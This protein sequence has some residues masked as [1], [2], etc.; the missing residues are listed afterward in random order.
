MVDPL[1]TY[2]DTTV[3][4]APDVTVFPDTILQGRCVIGAG[5]E[6]GPNTRLVDCVVGDGAVVEH[7]VARSAT[8]GDHAQVGPFAWLPPGTSIASGVE[9][10][11]FYTSTPD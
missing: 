6:L 2:I 11:P 1:R 4:L 8:I 10:G 9:S 7:T 5:V 3:Q